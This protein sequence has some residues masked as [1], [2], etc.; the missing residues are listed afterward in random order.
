M[1][2]DICIHNMPDINSVIPTAITNLLI[3]S[4]QAKKQVRTIIKCVVIGV[5]T[6]QVQ[7]AF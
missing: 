6:R 7:L 2:D 5:L 4:P 1:P 3:M